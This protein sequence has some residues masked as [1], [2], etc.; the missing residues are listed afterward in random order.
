MTALGYIEGQNIVYDVQH[1]HSDSV[2]AQRIAR[3][4]VED[5][6]DLI[7]AFPTEPSVAAKAA[8]QGTT[9]PVVFANANIEGSDLVESV[10]Q[11]GGNITGV[12]TLLSEQ[13]VKRLEI[14]LE[15]VPQATRIYVLYDANYPGT[16]AILDSLRR[17]AVSANIDLM[18][19]PATTLD[20]IKADLEARAAA[21]DPGI[22]AILMMPTALS[23]SPEAFHLINTFATEYNLP[24]AG[25]LPFMADQGAVFNYALDHV[26]VGKL[27]AP[28][29]DKIF[30]GTPAGTIPIVTA[31]LVL[32][33]NYTRAQELGITVSEGLLKMANEVIR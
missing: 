5:K 6:V 33:I 32:R 11:P 1:A 20:D 3:K 29:A 14:L 27:A 12:R 13:T 28:L 24:I 19:T 4:F 9:I 25:T 2:E 26:G 30:Q 8:T 22:D 31:E 21:D 7:L 23:A 10:Q 18:E 15:L 17:A 16:E